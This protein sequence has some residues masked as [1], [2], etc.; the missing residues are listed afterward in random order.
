MCFVFSNFYKRI[1]R[2]E[3]IVK[4]YILQLIASF[5]CQLKGKI[6]FFLVGMDD[7]HPDHGWQSRGR[8]LFRERLHLDQR[9]LSNR[10][11]VLGVN[12]CIS[13]F[14]TGC[15]CFFPKNFLYFVTSPSPGVLLVVKKIASE[16]KIF[17][18]DI[19]ARVGWQ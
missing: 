17:C 6:T 1:P 15:F 3:Q 5:D 9:A 7:S 11:Q 4:N 13:Y 16:W 2:Y 18:S 10:Y 19:Q 14:Y 12:I 8:I